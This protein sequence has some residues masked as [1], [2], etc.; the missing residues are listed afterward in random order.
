M[1]RLSE[2]I[3]HPCPSPSTLTHPMGCVLSPLFYQLLAC[4]CK[5]HSPSNVIVRFTDNMA[6]VVLVYSSSNNDVERQTSSTSAQPNRSM[7]IFTR[8]TLPSVLSTSIQPL[9]R[10]S[11]TQNLL[12]VQLTNTLSSRMNTLSII[13][14]A[15]QYQYLPRK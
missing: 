11:C 9:W 3:I 5:A 13:R 8:L 7:R 6:V 10:L 1:Y 4:C 14:K 2:S 12:R 15:H